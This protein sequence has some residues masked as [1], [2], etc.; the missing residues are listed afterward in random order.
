MSKKKS[1]S[2][3]LIEEFAGIIVHKLNNIM[4]TFFLLKSLY[5][6]D[7]KL[8]DYLSGIIDT[9]ENTKKSLEEFAQ[10]R[11]EIKKVF[12]IK[13][14]FKNVLNVAVQEDFKIRGDP[15]RFLLALNILKEYVLYEDIQTETIQNKTTIKIPL[16]KTVKITQMDFNQ[17]KIYYEYLDLLIVKKV[18]TRYGG[19]FVLTSPRL[20]EIS[21]SAEK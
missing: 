8:S 16:K 14:S 17:E 10:K 6:D 20:I 2:N 21:F 1:T 15:E 13:K 7:A 12:S 11:G 9:L 19:K 18:I 4:S 5:K 3:I